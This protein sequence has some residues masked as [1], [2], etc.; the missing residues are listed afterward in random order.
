MRDYDKLDLCI[1]YQKDEDGNGTIQLNKSL[2]IGWFNK[3]I[4][5]QTEKIAENEKTLVQ[6]QN[7][8]VL[9]EAEISGQREERMAQVDSEIAAYKREKQQAA[10]KELSAYEERLTELREEI[11][12]ESGKLAFL[13]TFQVPTDILIN[14]I[15]TIDDGNNNRYDADSFQDAISYLQNR[16]HNNYQLDYSVDILRDIW[17]GL[18]TGQMILLVGR[19]GTGKTSLVRYLAKAFGFA[20]AAIVPVQSGWSD[21]GDLLGYYNPLEKTYA[22]TPFLDKLLEFCKAARQ[23]PK[24][25]YFIC[26]DE[27]N[28]AHVEHYFAEFLSILQEREQQKRVLRLYSSNLRMDMAREL[29]LN[30]LL[31]EDGRPLV[32]YDKDKISESPAA[33]RKYYLELCR[34]AGMFARYPDTLEIPGNVKFFGT[35]NQDETTLDIS[36]KV[37]DRSYV[38]RL[39]RQPRLDQADTDTELPLRFHPAAEFV[40]LDNDDFDIS[41]SDIITRM[42]K[43]MDGKLSRRVLEIMQSDKLPAWEKTIGRKAVWDCLLASMILPRMRYEERTDAGWD[44]R[45]N[46]LRELCSGFP[47]S[48]EIFKAMLSADEDE[49]DFWRS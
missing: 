2:V 38:I 7:Q 27:M 9:L 16:L 1:Q 37:L 46:N 29:Q 15:S 36:P 13:E 43:V 22:A 34:Q 21:K 18:E 35:L 48:K 19:P 11:A 23:N 17:L 12:R 47:L 49:L 42:D 30:A 28:L 40:P 5:D 26:L 25:L 8:K 32:T 20:D 14:P 39:E 3:K 33:D 4:K 44:V 24:Q 41:S 31:G 6:L 45:I 10:D